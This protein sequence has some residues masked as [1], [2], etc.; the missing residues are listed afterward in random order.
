MNSLNK[1]GL[2]EQCQDIVHR[3]VRQDVIKRISLYYSKQFP[4]THTDGDQYEVELEMA[5][6]KL[7]VSKL[8]G[9]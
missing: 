7:S 9:D 8:D 6:V 5:I 1:F 4:L 2:L 3:I